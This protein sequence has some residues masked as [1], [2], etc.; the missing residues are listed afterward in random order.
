MRLPVGLRRRGYR[1]AYR[2]LLV[3]WFLARPSTRGVKCVLSLGDQVLLVRHTYGPAEWELPGGTLR[4]DEPPLDGTRRE[5]REELGIAPPEWL[6]LGTISGTLHHHSNTLHCFQAEL[7]ETALQ[8]DPGEIAS[9]AWFPRRALP[10]DLGRYVQPILTLAR[11][12]DRPPR[13]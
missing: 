9:A 8:I 6:E 7:S 13:G 4:H 11:P 5:I 12:V 3:Y 1:L 10:A 2:L